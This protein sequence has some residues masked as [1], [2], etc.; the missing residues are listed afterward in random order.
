MLS[1]TCTPTKR[2]TGQEPRFQD[3]VKSYADYTLYYNTLYTACKVKH[4]QKKSDLVPKKKRRGREIKKKTR[5]SLS[6]RFRLFLPLLL[7]LLLLLWRRLCGKG[8]QLILPSPPPPP[9]R[10]VKDI[11]IPIFVHLLIGIS[12]GRGERGN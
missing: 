8:Y 6:I 5:A 4:A 11:F 7:L 9:L 3:G 10:A 12:D 1:F 2:N